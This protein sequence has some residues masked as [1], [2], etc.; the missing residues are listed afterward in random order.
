MASMLCNTITIAV[1]D[2]PTPC[3]TLPFALRLSQPI[4]PVAH[5]WTVFGLMAV[6]VLNDVLQPVI[7]EHT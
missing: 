3:I 1:W 7:H 6:C 4:L 5:G 2:C